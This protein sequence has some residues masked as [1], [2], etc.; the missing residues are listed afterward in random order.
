MV[1]INLSNQ[2][3]QTHVTTHNVHT[4]LIDITLAY[5]S[6]KWLGLKKSSPLGAVSVYMIP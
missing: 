2:Y 5:K 4:S 1:N 3:L 6:S